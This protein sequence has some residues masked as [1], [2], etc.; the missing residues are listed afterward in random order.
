MTHVSGQARRQGSLFPESLDEVIAADHQ[1]RVID[2]F[3]DTLD[4]A[5]LGFCN[6]AAAATGRPPYAPGDLL[7]LYVYGYLNQVR[8]SRRLEREAAR[9]VEV[10][11]LINRLTP[12][13][14]TIADFRK[15]HPQ[16]IIGVCR[17]FIQFCRDQALFAAQLVAI[18]GTKIGAV[19]SRKKVLTPRRIAKAMA[20]LDGKIAAYLAEMDAADRS[21]PTEVPVRTDVA[22]AVA[23]LR[24]RRETLQQQAQMLAREGLRQRVTGEPDAKLMRTP[25]GHQVAY[26]AQIAVDDKHH[27]IAAFDLSNEGND[28]QQLHAMASQAKAALGAEQLTVAADVG[29]SSGEQGARC[30]A[31][32]I[33]A[34]VPR[35]EVANTSGKHYFSR[36]QFSYDRA[37]DSWRCPAG[38]TLTCRMT[39]PA[40]QRKRYATEACGG[41]ALK[42]QCTGA[43]RRLIY[44]SFYEDVVEAMH[45]R[46]SEDASWMKRRRELAEHPFG[47]IKWLMGLPRFLLR[48]LQKAKAELALGVISYNLKRVINLLGVRALL[49]TLQ[50]C[51]N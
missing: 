46:A 48:G 40:R 11:W 49:Q 12:A 30:A 4:L 9:N 1:V 3:V 6:V 38:A 16:A 21:E 43:A 37:T 7:K 20:A 13:F 36:D 15:D 50:P 45:Q 31:D 18:D 39:S 44:R 47:T 14:K 19:A 22:A 42:A 24:E 27:L 34:V 33:T 8:S 5:Q 35:A 17:A 2:A 29:Y 23:A 28:Q 51:R 26:N 10:M 25:H 41:C 32:N